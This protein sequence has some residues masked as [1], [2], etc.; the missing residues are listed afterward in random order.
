M[1]AP[2]THPGAGARCPPGG[3]CSVLPGKLPLPR[4]SGRTVAARERPVPPNRPGLPGRGRGCRPGRAHS[5]AVLGHLQLR[6]RKSGGRGRSGWFE[7]RLLDILLPCVVC[8]PQ[9]AFGG[10][11]RGGS[12]KIRPKEFA[13]AHLLQGILRLLARWEEESSE[14]L[15]VNVQ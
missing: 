7:M 2:H 3:R 1:G 11:E 13:E 4:P 10:G 15:D 12:P 14:R 8:F 6:A 9:P 5:T